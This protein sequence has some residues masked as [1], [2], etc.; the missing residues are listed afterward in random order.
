MRGDVF[1]VEVPSLQI[2]L[3]GFKLTKSQPEHRRIANLSP[4][5]ETQFQ[6]KNGKGQGSRV[7]VFPESSSEGLG[8]WLSGTVLT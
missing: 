4:A 2:S 1:F 5:Q 6:N 8:A 7:D 3:A